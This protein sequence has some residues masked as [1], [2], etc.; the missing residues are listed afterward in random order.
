M[1]YQPINFFFNSFELC[2]ALNHNQKPSQLFCTIQS[3]TTWNPQNQAG[4]NSGQGNPSCGKKPRAAPG[5]QRSST[6]TSWGDRE[7]QKMERERDKDRKTR[8]QMVRQAR[9]SCRVNSKALII[10]MEVYINKYIKYINTGHVYVYDTYK[11][12]RCRDLT[13]LTRPTCTL[14]GCVSCCPHRTCLLLITNYQFEQFCQQFNWVS[15]II[16]AVGP[17]WIDRRASSVLTCA[18]REISDSQRGFVPF[19]T[20]IHKCPALHLDTAI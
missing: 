6:L 10:Q 3:K 15:G 7:I 17:V 13:H 16:A 14:P 12:C 2:T 19:N 11:W 18:A 8:S 9:A 20:L 4:W 5:G 1:D